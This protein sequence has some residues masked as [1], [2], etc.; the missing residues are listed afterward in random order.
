MEY[1][2]DNDK[3]RRGVWAA[4]YAMMRGA[5]QV[6]FQ[7]SVLTGLLFLAGI[8]WGA[9][10]TGT[11]QVF[12]GALVGLVV[13]TITGCLL[14]LPIDEGDAGLWGFNGI[15]VGCAFPT[16]LSSTPLMWV[17]LIVCSMLTVWVRTGMNRLLAPFKVNSLTFPFVFTTWLFMLAA[18]ML[19]AMP[20][21]DLSNP[22]LVVVHHHLHAFTP[23]LFVVALFKGIA[24]VFLIDSAITGFIFLIALAVSSMR[25]ALWALIG[26]ALSLL[27]ALLYGAPLSEVA[28]GLY[29]FSPV[30]T[31]IAL[32]ATFYRHNLRTT[33]WTLLGITVTLFVQAGMNG[34]MLPYGL[35]TFTAPFCL[36]TWI[37]LLP[38]YKFDSREPDHTHWHKRRTTVDEP[39]QTAVE[40]T[41]TAAEPTKTSDVKTKTN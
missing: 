11:H 30:L 20:P 23:A 28:H 8:L 31:A 35:P 1:K 9:V 25:A 36:V 21:D 24:Q 3:N 13:S 26:S 27:L 16:F 40:P 7:N 29:G 18:R 2:I 32:G 12:I 6:M 5:G 37:F 19:W 14:R 38:L 17:A 22:E 33:L 41:K 34:L 4:T 15:L 39:T 10:S